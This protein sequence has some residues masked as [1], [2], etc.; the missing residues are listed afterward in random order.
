M[1][2]GAWR[3]GTAAGS[4]CLLFVTSS[5][6]GAPI[7]LTLSDFSSEPLTVPAEHLDARM[8]FTVSGDKLTL[9]VAND[10]EAP[11]TFRINET[12]FNATSNVTGLQWWSGS[13]TTGW[14]LGFGEDGYLVDGFGL[15]DV[16]L[17]DGL[18]VDANQIFPGTT[19]TFEFKIL[20]TSPF[21]ELDFTTELSTPVD[22][23]ID[24][25]AAA[26]FVDSGNISGYGNVVPEPG[27]LSL[28]LFGTL[29][30]VRRHTR[31]RH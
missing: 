16:S 5:G 14:A 11:N 21:S 31:R 15:L 3:L 6:E 9:E 2:G 18:G 24:S 26:K 27:T 20:G 4:L 30:L 22:G 25:L 29:R 12:Y 23:H 7:T 19:K 10:T 1:N 13:P 28:L 8:T 17:T